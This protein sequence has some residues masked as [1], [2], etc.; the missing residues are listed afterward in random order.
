[1]IIL[2]EK[3]GELDMVNADNVVSVKTEVKSITLN[4]TDGDSIKIEFDEID[5]Y[6][7]AVNFIRNKVWNSIKL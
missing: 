7:K 3:D 6:K 1:M 2:G 5:E 4:L